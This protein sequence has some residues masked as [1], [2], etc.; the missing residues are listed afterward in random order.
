L[1]K[2]LI[3]KLMLRPIKDPPN[4]VNGTK[5]PDTAARYLGA[6]PGKQIK[7]E[8]DHDWLH[9]RRRALW[10]ALLLTLNQRKNPFIKATDLA[11]YEYQFLVLA[12][13]L[14]SPNMRRKHVLAAGLT[15]FVQGLAKRLS[16]TLKEIFF[17]LEIC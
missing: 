10:I 14:S 9:T 5:G 13:K 3:A 6:L 11:R 17:A 15:Q 12:R 2:G 1:V 4:V 7:A 8:G 16:L